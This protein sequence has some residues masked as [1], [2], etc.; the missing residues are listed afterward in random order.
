MIAGL[1]LAAGASTR[2][3]R[4][5]AL[6]RVG[7]DC[8][9]TRVVRTMIAAGL[10]DISVVAGD[11]AARIR[12]AL[13]AAGLMARVVDH[14][15]WRDGQLS[16]LQAG[17][18]A[19]EPLHADAV[20]I[21]LVDVPLVSPETMRLVVGAWR[22]RR[23]P[24]V[25]PARDGRHGHPVLFDRAVFGELLAADPAAGAK[26]VVRAHATEAVDVAVDDEGA[27]QDVDTPE[28]YA[29]LIGSASGT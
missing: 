22:K 20:V 28:D 3:G 19:L 17:L 27:F 15:N 14:A 6:L 21:S 16:S 5:K 1:V 18:L 13:A 26:A 2:M 24:I 11:E 12:A 7:E 23:A 8:F 25:R 9:V 10:G 29:R 4:P